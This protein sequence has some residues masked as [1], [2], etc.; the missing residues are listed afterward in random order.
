[1]KHGLFVR[2]VAPAYQIGETVKVKRYLPPVYSGSLV[3]IL[4]INT[5][6]QGARYQ[7]RPTEYP[8]G[9]VWADEDDLEWVLA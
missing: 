3:T 4:E 5:E 7:V 8:A 1:M 2:K 6:G 9:P